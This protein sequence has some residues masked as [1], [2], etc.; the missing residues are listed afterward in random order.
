MDTLQPFQSTTLPFKDPGETLLVEFDFSAE[1]AAGETIETAVIS[2]V[3][4]KG[5]DVNP[6]GILADAAQLTTP[7]V[8]QLISGGVDGSYYKISC[9]A[10]TSG[11]EIIILKAVV[12]VRR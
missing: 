11:G 8:F 4:L 12:P 1:L 6:S 5:Y 10:S 7:K 2:C 3:L 9:T